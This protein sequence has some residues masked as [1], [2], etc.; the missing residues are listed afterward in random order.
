MIDN[1]GTKHRRGDQDFTLSWV[2]AAMAMASTVALTGCR[3]DNSQFVAGGSAWDA[4]EH[5]GPKAVSVQPL[6]SRDVGEVSIG[7]LAMWDDGVIW[8]GELR[9]GAIWELS[10][11]RTKPLLM[12][13]QS[14]ETGGPGGTLAMVSAPGHGML[15]LG[16]NGVSRFQERTGPS[17]FVQVHRA[18][19]KGFAAFPNGDYVIAYG[20]YRDDPHR[21]YAIH[22]YDLAGNHIASWHPAYPDPDW[23]RV[24][25]LSGGPLAVTAKGDLLFSEMAPFRIIRF[26][27]GT[28]SDA[29]VVV[30]NEDIVSSA[31]F[32]RAAPEPGVV[33]FRWSRSVFVDELPDGHI[34]NIVRFYPD[35]RR[36][37]QT[38]WLIV[39]RDGG[40]VARTV[41][42]GI[43][44]VGART[45][46]N[47]YLVVRQ[48]V[49]MEVEVL[50]VLR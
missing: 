17:D 18:E 32:Q 49:L 2:I 42:D 44:R 41:F 1:R 23:V 15:I 25:H 16:R 30:E 29:V 34:L 36:E 39:S 50:P 7:G 12:R 3:A 6:W 40:I 19:A 4:V 31:E 20:Q 8:I 21:E 9:S 24:A 37:T 48:G 43:Q 33:A 13:R 5:L 46:W 28:G 22:R 14:D 38:H 11:D 47:T 10:T 35:G 26:L 45:P 27:G